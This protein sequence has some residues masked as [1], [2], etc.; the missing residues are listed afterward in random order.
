MRLSYE[1]SFRQAEA[2]YIE[3]IGGA[4]MLLLM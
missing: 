4:P 1:E 3:A 2:D